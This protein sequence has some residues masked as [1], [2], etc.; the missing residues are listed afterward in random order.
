MNAAIA[1]V[2]LVNNKVNNPLENTAGIGF[3]Q[4]WVKTKLSTDAGSGTMSKSNRVGKW[5]TV[6]TTHQMAEVM[7]IISPMMKKYGY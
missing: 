5:A 7:P 4:Q 6:L 2:R 3:E 1:K